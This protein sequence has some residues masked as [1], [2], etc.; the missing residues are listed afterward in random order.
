[1]ATSR[2][3]QRGMKMETEGEGEATTN[4]SRCTTGW[5]RHIGEYRGRVTW[6]MG[7]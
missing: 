6:D 3:Y 2:R 1:M 4:D 5:E 7:R